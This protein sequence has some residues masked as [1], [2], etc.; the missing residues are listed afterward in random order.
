[1]SARL[2]G[3]A[4]PLAVLLPALGF[5][6][7]QL[8]R[9]GQLGLPIDDAWIHAA[10]AR[11]ILDGTPFQLHAGAEI[12]PGSSAPLWTLLL[13]PLHAAGSALGLATHERA[14]AAAFVLGLACAIA[15]AGALRSLLRSLEV[16][17]PWCTGALLVFALSPRWV[18][19]TLSGLE[20][21]LYTALVLGALASH[22]AAKRAG[23]ASHVALPLAALAGW[24]RPECFVLPALLAL[25]AWLLP[26]RGAAEGA[27]APRACSGRALL[28]AGG[29]CALYA[30]AHLWLY[31]RPLPTTFYVK[32]EFASPAGALATG[33]VLLALRL[34]AEQALR[35]FLAA[36]AFFPAQILFLAPWILRGA[37]GVARERSRSGTALL[38]LL[39]LFPLLQGA[40]KFHYPENQVGRYL[41][42]QIVPYLA[43]AAVGLGAARG[44]RREHTRWLFLLSG[45]AALLALAAA[46]TYALGA[47]LP[48]GALLATLRFVLW[49]DIER[50]LLQASLGFY[51]QS[52]AVLA[53]GAL[54]LALLGLLAGAALSERARRGAAALS[55]A[56]AVLFAALSCVPLA[57][58]LARNVEET[59][60]I[61]VASGRWLAEH[62]H[63]DDLVA[64][65]DLGA[66]AYFARCRVLDLQGI[67]SPRVLALP[68]GADGRRELAPLLLAEKPRFYAGFLEWHQQDLLALLRS[69]RE[70]LGPQHIRASF[71]LDETVTLGGTDFLVIELPW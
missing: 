53:L 33:D 38:L 26:A 16:E 49:N 18:W 23:R 29:L 24:S 57:R 34:A 51:T 54:A 19:G 63:P 61:S 47:E 50:G 3:R 59:E 60:R 41:W 12:A 67:G 30:G 69:L 11:T 4:A 17:E 7:V 22:V 68:R 15:A 28:L 58:L 42:H 66:I 6:L 35:Q 37:L 8:V 27:R 39:V 21:A 70:P 46:A 43:L 14:V 13:A 56:L 10:Y 5:A 52:S 62:A 65:H 36:L 44:E 25:D 48:R 9:T 31:G 40:V 55:A 20:V 45:A 2:H 32:A 64:L 1:M 71:S